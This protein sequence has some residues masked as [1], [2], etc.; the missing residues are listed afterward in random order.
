M[1][2]DDRD[3]VWDELDD[4][5]LGPG[6]SEFKASTCEGRARQAPPGSD[7]WAEFLLVAAGH[8]I[9]LGQPDV[10]IR[11]LEAVRESGVVS[12]PSVEAH[13]VDAYLKAGREDDFVAAEKALRRRSA[14]VH[15]GADYSFVGESL[16]EAGR[17]REA[18]R[19]FTMA[20][21]EVDPDELD[22]LDVVALNGRYRVRRQLGLPEDAYDLSALE[23]REIANAQHTDLPES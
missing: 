17:L 13:L 20:N 15:L 12:E 23:L 16:E 22:T 11:H 2:G 6:D 3:D 4:I 9:M 1:L 21:R 10:A 8:R 7:R 5:E 18:L 19:W 14:D